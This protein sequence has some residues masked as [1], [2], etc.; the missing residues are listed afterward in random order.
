MK[1]SYF[2]LLLCLLVLLSS[3]AE[4]GNTGSSV[5]VSTSGQTAAESAEMVPPPEDAT[6]MSEIGGEI[7]EDMLLSE[8]DMP[9]EI[10]SVA[11]GDIAAVHIITSSD[12]TITRE[13]YIDCAISVVDP[14]GTYETVSGVDCTIKVRGHS[15]SRGEKKPFN[16]KFSSKQEL[17]GLGE[18]KK[19]ALLANM[20]D[21]T[22]LRNLLAFG[23]ADDIGMPY[24][25]QS[26]FVDVYL[27]GEYLGIYQ[28]C[29]PVDVDETKVDI[30]EEGNEALLELEPRGGYSN[31]HWMRSPHYGLVLGFNAPEEPT[32][33]QL[34]YYKEFLGLAEQA[35]ASGDY[36]QVCQYVDVNSFA[37]AYIV[38]ELFK[39]VDYN[40]SSTRFYIKEG[41][42]YEGPVWDFDLSSGNCSSY[43]YP[44]YNNKGTTGLSWQGLHCV[45]LW[46]QYLFRYEEF[47][48]L[49]CDRL[50]E[51]QP[52]IVN[53]YED[54]EL[55]RSQIDA[56]LD[57][58]REDIER[59]NELWPTDVRGNGYEH[60]PVDGTYDGEIRFLRDWLKNRNQWLLDHYCG[61]ET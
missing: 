39:Q 29:E 23:F 12:D 11:L 2:A 10:R 14:S 38:Q 27:N 49:V 54:N 55:G 1:R 13:A 25:Q 20:Y 41:K 33:T 16:F 24:V 26:T 5:S 43:L 37:N 32:D 56:W 59:N 53:L 52:V 7:E 28:L 57:E 22:Q 8:D 6:S 18:G 3:C 50:Q 19:W 60:T 9:D 51:L 48:Q 31:D 44:E 61:G 46:N 47:E 34:A 4:S 30:D 21:K 40:L 15:S 58:Y 17:L 42:L 45:G 36:S 35:M